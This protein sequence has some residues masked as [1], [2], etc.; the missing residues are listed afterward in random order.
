MD[1]QTRSIA[2]A[3]ASES[4]IVSVWTKLRASS[5]RVGGPW[6]GRNDAG[7]TFRSRVAE[8]S[9]EV[10]NHTGCRLLERV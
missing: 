4:S 10:G 9:D 2:P 7:L 5:A 1:R 8:S 6:S 3:I